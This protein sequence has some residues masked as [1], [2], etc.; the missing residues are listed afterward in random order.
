MASSALL[1]LTLLL[2]QAPLSQSAETL[3]SF[4]LGHAEADL[5]LIASPKGFA[6]DRIPVQVHRVLKGKVETTRVQVLQPRSYG[7]H[8]RLPTKASPHLIFLKKTPSGY[9]PL[10]RPGLLIPVPSGSRRERSLYAF[11]K[12]LDRAAAHKPS[13]AMQGKDAICRD[14]ARFATSHTQADSLLAQAALLTLARRPDL[15]PAMPMPERRRIAALLT[16]TGLDAHLRDLSARTLAAARHPALQA[17][18]LTLLAEGRAKGLGPVFGRLLAAQKGPAPLTALST[19]WNKAGPE[20][21]AEI[22]QTLNAY[23]TPAAKKLRD[24]LR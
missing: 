3:P 1:F 4:D 22:R 6:G 21:R 24:S 14:L 5:V 18:L 23:A 19:A 9:I 20:A 15:A 17:Q 10:Q 7:L 16:D 13:T 8:V 2:P 11:F 12:L